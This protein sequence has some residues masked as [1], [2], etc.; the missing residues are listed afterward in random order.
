MIALYFLNIAVGAYTSFYPVEGQTNSI[1][2]VSEELSII[3]LCIFYFYEQVNNPEVTFLYASKE[4][5]IVLG[6]FFYTT[7]TLFLFVSTNQLSKE[8]QQEF[9]RISQIG[10]MIKNILFIVA[11]I[12]PLQKMAVGISGRIK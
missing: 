3:V 8:V 5:W 4:F 9:W 6:F 1:F 10:N 2:V 12:K 11:F 7:S